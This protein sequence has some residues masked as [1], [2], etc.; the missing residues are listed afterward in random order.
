MN[1]DT[2]TTNMT[3]EEW[4]EIQLNENELFTVDVLKK[5]WNTA[6]KKANHE[7]SWREGNFFANKVYEECKTK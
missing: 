2:F 5:C 1:E 7:W 4:L 3:F 6:I